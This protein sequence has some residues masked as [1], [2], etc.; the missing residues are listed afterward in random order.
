MR[1]V[2]QQSEDGA[3]IVPGGEQGV[4]C[5]AGEA[6]R[7]HGDGEDAD[8]RDAVAEGVEEDEVE[9]GEHGEEGDEAELEE[10]AVK[11]DFGCG[12]GE[13]GGG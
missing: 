9:G 7:G 6:A 3:H 2:S 11:V 4:D 10:G 1:F 8:G 12:D 13:G 5:E